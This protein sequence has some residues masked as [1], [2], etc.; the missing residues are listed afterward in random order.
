MCVCVCVCVCVLQ[1]NGGSG[2]IREGCWIPGEE[3]ACLL[4]AG[5]GRTQKTLSGHLRRVSS[6]CIYGVSACVVEF[7][8]KTFKSAH[9]QF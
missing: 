6:T 2:F 7:E 9:L 8:R 4:Q 5:P 3:R 1:F